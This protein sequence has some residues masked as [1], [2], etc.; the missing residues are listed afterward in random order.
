MLDA[1]TGRSTHVVAMDSL[2]HYELPQIVAALEG[3][4]ARCAGPIVFTV[5]PWTPFLGTL[6]NVGRLFP[7]R[8]RAPRIVPTAARRLRGAVEQARALQ[9]W[10]MGRSDHIEQGFY[11]R[12]PMSCVRWFPVPTTVL[13]QNPDELPAATLAVLAALGVW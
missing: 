2:I 7:Q 1:P 6:I 3:L 4:A 5:A 12:R 13:L 11:R 8:D 10:T 9:G